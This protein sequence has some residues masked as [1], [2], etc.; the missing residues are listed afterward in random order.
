[1]IG[2]SHM[3]TTSGVSGEVLFLHLGGGSE[4][5]FDRYIFKQ[6]IYFVWFSI[7]VFFLIF[8]DGTRV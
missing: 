3:Q 1:V 6:Y 4:G 2:Q 7:F 5:I 8:F